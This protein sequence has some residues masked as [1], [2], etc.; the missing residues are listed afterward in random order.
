[1][2]GSITWKGQ[3]G[4]EFRIDAE[5]TEK[6]AKDTS[7]SDGYTIEHGMKPVREALMTVHVDGK[8]VDDSRND[9]FWHCVEISDKNLIAM[10][11][12]HKIG[13]RVGVPSELVE[14]IDVMLKNVIEVGKTEDPDVAAYYA[15]QNAKKAE[16]ARKNAE[17]VIAEAEKSPKNADGTLMNDKQA[18][19][20]QKAFNNAMNDGAEGYVPEIITQGQYDAA[21]KVLGK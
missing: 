9:A 1:M 4:K 18:A 13:S 6:M 7:W 8:Q 17:W 15:A 5:Y 3:T 20:Y 10:G 16:K 21:M 14:Q 11:I 19:A 12:T 2:K